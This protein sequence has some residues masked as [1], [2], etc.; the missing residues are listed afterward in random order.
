VNG[1]PEIKTSKKGRNQR[2]NNPNTQTISPKS[3]YNFYYLS[4]KPGTKRTFLEITVGTEKE[5][6]SM[7]SCSVGLLF[8]C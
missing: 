3:C 2:E 8:H 5:A 1:N 6:D 7:E 4:R